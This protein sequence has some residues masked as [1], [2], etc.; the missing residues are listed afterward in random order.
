MHRGGR[1]DAQVESRPQ[2][3][4]AQRRAGF[5]RAQRFPGQGRFEIHVQPPP[6][7]MGSHGLHVE[8]AGQACPRA[9]PL[10][11]TQR[12]CGA[13]DRG[14]QRDVFDRQRCVARCCDHRVVDLQ[15]FDLQRQR[16]CQVRQLRWCLVGRRGR[17]QRQLQPGDLDGIHVHAPGE[18]GL[19]TPVEHQLPD[20]NLGLCDRD[21]HVVQFQAPEQIAAAVRIPELDTHGPTTLCQLTQQPVTACLATQQAPGTER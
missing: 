19:R 3:A 15:A 5:D 16:Q 4:A 11:V 8:P 17:R 9:D 1:A 18:Q 7:C 20:G 10:Q 14:T 21:A 6:Q 2:Q 12:H 13:V